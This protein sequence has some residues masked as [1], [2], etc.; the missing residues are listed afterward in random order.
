MLYRLLTNCYHGP[1]FGY[2]FH[3]VLYVICLYTTFSSKISPPK[4]GCMSWGGKLISAPKQK[5]ADTEV[6]TV[7]P[8]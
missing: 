6:V 2:S 5:H 1:N 7:L 4:W 3:S 8:S